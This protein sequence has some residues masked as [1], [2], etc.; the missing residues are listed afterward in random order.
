MQIPGRLPP[1][2]CFFLALCV[3]TW[4][5][6]VCMNVWGVCVH[7]CLCVCVLSYICVCVSTSISSHH[8]HLLLSHL[9]LLLLG[10]LHLLPLLLDLR[11]GQFLLLVVG[12]QELLP[13]AD[14]LANHGRKLTLLLLQTLWG[15][16][17]R[18]RVGVRRMEGEGEGGVEMST[19]SLS[20]KWDINVFMIIFNLLYSI[21]LQG[22]PSLNRATWVA[23]TFASYSWS[24]SPCI[25]HCFH[26]GTWLQCIS[27]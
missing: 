10:Q 15:T 13:Q 4:V 11:G 5:S 7:V 6:R 17:R 8:T 3:G 12:R 2:C 21:H 24:A 16:W 26:P 18:A 14:E 20:Y 9:V 25:H 27:K 23:L 22:L 19:K 1:A